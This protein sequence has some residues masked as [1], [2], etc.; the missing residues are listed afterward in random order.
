[1]MALLGGFGAACAVHLLS[2]SVCCCGA[3]VSG[4]PDGFVPSSA[5]T[6]A[7]VL[8]VHQRAVLQLDD[9]VARANEALVEAASW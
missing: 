5:L 7:L 6:G 1:M 4:Y 8:K 3:H 9:G 2:C